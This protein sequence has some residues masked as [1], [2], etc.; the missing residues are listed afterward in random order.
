MPD[1]LPSKAELEIAHV[2][3]LDVVAYSTLLINEQ[4]SIVAEL[5]QVV[6]ET[7]H[8]RSGEAAQQLIR[9]PTGDGMALVFF[10][11]PE[12]P[13]QCALELCEALRSHPH[14]HVRMGIH[15]GPVNSVADVNERTSVA[16]SGINIARR[17]MDCAD[18]GHI[19]LS[20]RVAE[21]LSQYGHWQ[22]KL[23]DLGEIEVKHGTIVSVFNLYGEGF[24]NSEVPNRMRHRRHRFPSQH[25][26]RQR[27]VLGGV[28]LAVAFACLGAFLYRWVNPS[29]RS[30]PNLPPAKSVAVLPFDNF[31]DD[32]QNS[33]LADGVQDDILTA[34]SRISDLKVISRGSVM[35]Y[36][37]KERNL[38]QIGR[39][40][41]VAY[42]LEGS[43]R[44]VKE[45][46]RITAQLINVRT[47]SHVWAE[48]Y[49]RKIADVFAIQDEIA[50]RIVSSLRATLSSTEKAAI[51]LPPTRDMEAFDLFLQG[52]DLIRTFNDT[53]NRKETLLRAIRLLDEAIARDSS[54]ALAY[55]WA[56]TAHD[57]LYWFNLDHS[58]TRLELAKS[59][60]RQALDLM[61]DLGEA[62]LAQA[63]IL[64]HGYRDYAQARQHVAI[65]ARSLPNNAEVYSLTGYIDRREGKW[66][67]SLHNLQRAAELDPRNFKILSDLSV[68]FDLLR[69][70]DDKEELIAR[71]IA[72]NP[73]QTD[74]WQLIRAD[75]ELQKGNLPQAR[76]LADKFPP[77]YDPDGAA[78]SARILI[79]LYERNGEAARA[80]LDACKHD[81]LVD[82]TG[83]LVPR[84]FF[85]GQ[86]YR[87]L[88]NLTQ[89]KATFE[90]ARD[91]IEQDLRD[92][93]DN[94]L[95]H[96]VLCVIN[97]GLSRREQALSEGRRA[98]ELRPINKD[99]VDGPV[100]L[101]RLAMAEAWLRE[102]DAAIE[103][104]DYLTKIP[105]GPDYGQLKF[106]PAWDGLRDD[107]RFVKI[108]DDL[109]PRP[110][111]R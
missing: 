101:T 37:D 64:Y 14:I 34:L 55:C 103:N 92:D 81:E 87:S 50:E 51:S 60:V 42:L 73:A 35:R 70:Y 74:Y 100:V 104:L 91:K 39:E 71:A 28:L 63:L 33:Y 67:E 47:D 77:Q 49:D 106:D 69:R 80:A 107:A 93:P 29:G 72:I 41:N 85:G 27:L 83:S 76:Q 108:V 45:E 25:R 2:L 40:L 66:D 21:D 16:G 5:N 6:K 20:K 57:N 10:T 31:S 8:F 59:C 1:D 48:H 62:H 44:R 4:S 111:R 18:A 75:T 17:I 88:G 3:F 23:H 53:P 7:P 26:K 19:L 78:T 22:P 24:G 109:R 96:G 36:R 102:N 58:P 99:A 94:A 13:V 82:G 90:T 97:A 79:F 68:L 110:T 30:A 105:G 9:I 54:F 38:P 11:N 12:A 84:G 15:S 46:I 65:A 43:V 95:L 98:V 86:V 32:K 89:A 56:A 52:R 61:P